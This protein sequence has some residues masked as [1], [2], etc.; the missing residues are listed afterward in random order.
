[1]SI[2]ASG[3]DESGAPPEIGGNAFQ[4][5]LG[6]GRRVMIVR[7]SCS[8]TGSTARSKAGNFRPGL[9]RFP[10]TRFGVLFVSL[11]DFRFG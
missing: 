8:R 9:D 4:R 11:W 5:W 2:S 3:D 10:R 7:R 6:M 1:M